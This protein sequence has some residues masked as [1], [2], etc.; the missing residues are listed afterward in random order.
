MI[1]MMELLITV[2]ISIG[3]YYILTG[4][5]VLPTMESKKAINSLVQDKVSIADQLIIPLANRLEKHIQLDELRRATLKTKLYSAELHC[6]PEY[7]VAK[8]TATGLVFML[9]A[10][11]CYIITPIISLVCIL[12]GI[13]LYFQ[14]INKVDDII[15]KKRE[16]IEGELVLFSTT[17]KQSL[18]TSRD[19]LHILDSFRK[20]CSI[21]FRKELD[22]TI[23]DMKTGSYEDALK[24]FDERISSSELSE[25]V[26]GL[27]AVMR[28]DDQTIYFEIL[29][30][31]LMAKQKE[32]IK[33]EALR[34]PDKMKPISYLMMFCFLAMFMYGIII[35]MADTMKDL[36]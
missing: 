34:R 17:I 33:R 8:A 28:G 32:S 11:P 3:L 30:H 26:S 24:R 13:L 22:I 25:I 1:S 15:K 12:F 20:V 6:T 5:I 16:K 29:S 31:D 9:L 14:E 36:F 27:L 10:I 7:Y 35:Q 21:D 18:A 19:V 2:L 23:A 4:I